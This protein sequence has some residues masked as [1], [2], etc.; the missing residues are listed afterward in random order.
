MVVMC[1]RHSV[2]L[3]LINGDGSITTLYYDS[4]KARDA[5]REFY[6]RHGFQ[7]K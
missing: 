3:R 2:K 1:Q 5:D 6:L 4:R 7:C